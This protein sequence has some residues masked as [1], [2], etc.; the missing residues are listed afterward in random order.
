MTTCYIIR[1]AEKEKGDFYNPLLR[2]HGDHLPAVLSKLEAGPL[3]SEIAEASSVVHPLYWLV[4]PPSM[5]LNVIPNFY[6]YHR[7][8]FWIIYIR[9]YTYYSLRDI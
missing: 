6:F 2:H 5:D 1:H 4:F 3:Q 7:C 8:Y 9:I